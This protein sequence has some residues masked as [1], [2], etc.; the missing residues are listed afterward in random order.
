[1]RARFGTIQGSPQ[2]RLSPIFES[3]TYWHSPARELQ[4]CG[5][6]RRA[7]IQSVLRA[8]LPQLTGLFYPE[9]RVRNEYHRW[10]G[11]GRTR[12]RD[13]RLSGILWNPWS[14]CQIAF[15]A[16]DSP[17]NQFEGVAVRLRS[18]MRKGYQ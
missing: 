6:A 13:H 15:G 11:E 16:F 10:S 9:L 18:F 4:L 5:I 2:L 17:M 1:M 12:Q 3:N 7:K 8:L 14:A